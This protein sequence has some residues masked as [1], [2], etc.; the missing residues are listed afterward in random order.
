MPTDKDSMQQE[1]IIY[2]KLSAH[3]TSTTSNAII[4]YQLQSLSLY[5]FFFFFLFIP[6]LFKPLHEPFC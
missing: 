3:I 4:C 2:L 1:H 5:L 6:C